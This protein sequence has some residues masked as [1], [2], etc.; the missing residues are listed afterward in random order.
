MNAATHQ[1]PCEIC[2]RIEQ[3]RRG[4]HPGL[5][6]EL[7]TG[8]A[9]L[10]DVQFFAG[11]SLLYCK[12]LATELDDLPRDVRV[13]YLEEMAQLAAAVR[14]VVQPYKLNY[15]CLGNKVHHLHWHVF[16]RYPDDPQPEKPVWGQL[17]LGREANDWKFSIARHGELRDR[18]R[19]TLMEIRRNDRAAGPV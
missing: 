9:V 12:H 8:W 13:R 11:Y 17:P 6:A 1:S 14:S 15:E 4:E 19:Q 16:P 3:C 10:G 5:I 2:N 7:D 18:L